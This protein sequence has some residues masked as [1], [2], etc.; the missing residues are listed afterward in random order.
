M[1]TVNIIPDLKIMLE[2][3]SPD[4]DDVYLEGYEAGLNNFA[5]AGNPYDFNSREHEYWVE[6]WWGGYLGEE[7]VF[8]SQLLGTVPKQADASNEHVAQD[9]LKVRQQTITEQRLVIG[10]KV[11]LVVFAALF[12]YNSIE[13]AV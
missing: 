10:F 6:G 7:P 13:L 1:S 9:I 2:K 11:A 4:L 3:H 5:E 8:E 12:V